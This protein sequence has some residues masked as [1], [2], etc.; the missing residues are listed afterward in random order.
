[1]NEDERQRVFAALSSSVEE[2]RYRATQKLG[3]EIGG[4]D[5]PGL[6]DQLLLALGD[7]SWRVRKCAA[8]GMSRIGP[9][10]SL[11]TRLVAALGED[12]NAG[13]RNSASEVL[14]DM[15][16]PAL[17]SLL[18]LL[19]DG[20]K[21]ERKMAADILGDIGDRRAVGQLVK[22]LNDA[23]ENVRAAAAEALGMLGDR[24][25]G[26]RLIELLRSDGLL[27]QLSCLDALDRL[28]TE[29]PWE[30]LKELAAVGPLRPGLFRLMGRLANEEVLPVLM[31]GLLA[32][33]RAERASAAHALA[34][35]YLLS[36]K[37]R[38]IEIQ[39]AVAR[40]ASDGMIS[41]LRSLLE[42]S[43]SDDREAA[44]LIFGWSGREDV[45]EDLLRAA[46]DE[47]LVD[48]VYEAI[49]LIG[50]KAAPVLDGL[51]EQVGRVEKTLIVNL[52][53]HFGRPSSI[54]II[55]D[56]SLSDEPEVAEAA[57]QALA[58]VGNSSVVST[59]VGYLKRNFEFHP[60]GVIAAL[61]TLG[62][63]FHDEVV[64]A[65]RPLLQENK[66]SLRSPAAEIFCGVARKTDMD[67][68]N[69]LLQDEDDQI[70][71]V[72]LDS[73]GRIGEESELEKLRFALTDES[74]K[75]RTAAARALGMR[76]DPEARK[77][78]QIAL[79]DP[80]PWVV[81]EALASL[82]KS[83]DI[84]MAQAIKSFVDNPNGLVAMEA[85]RA[86]NELGGDENPDWLEKASR[87]PDSEVV[88]E[89]ISGCDNWPIDVV[90]PILLAALADEHWDVR[91]AAAKKIG[92]LKDQ[93]A[94]SA[95]Y[96]Q[97]RVEKDDLVRETLERVLKA[98]RA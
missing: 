4:R 76:D 7:S 52:L 67:E 17:D 19:S 69:R 59:L 97:L 42:S 60:E 70:R 84:S 58:K 13:L 71:S 66:T 86:L 62:V 82:G 36:D 21:D 34:E 96:E 50:P 79:A 23:D 14:T 75:V 91:A 2:I 46:S 98:P 38:R 65:I 9:D 78:L 85:V 83:G 1:M 55:I 53:G 49:L 30:L 39:V 47:S 40:A 56:L 95:V 92:I 37:H 51:V 25:V 29:T 54:A 43:S 94:L 3:Q 35:Q 27:V 68:I 89:V 26:G 15:G 81:R 20:S 28:N 74:P 48:L 5:V 10:P 31:E 8:D 87:H 57:Q 77:V 11:I 63:R 6:V 45:V 90:R 33:G 73:L 18:A 24:Q 93:E 22:I 80:E 16:S 72:A 61:I 88:K 12:D 64:E 32:R 41:H 44:I